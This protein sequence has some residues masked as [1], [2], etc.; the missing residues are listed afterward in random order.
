MVNIMQAEKKAFCKT[1]AQ[2]YPG[3][4]DLQRYLFRAVPGRLAA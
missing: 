3:R 4:A 1:M 2:S